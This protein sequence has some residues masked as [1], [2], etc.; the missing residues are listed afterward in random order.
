MLAGVL[1]SAAALA[2]CATKS[3]APTQS[4]GAPPNLAWDFH[5]QQVGEHPAGSVFL[6]VNGVPHKVVPVA[7]AN[8]EQLQRK[9]YKDYSVPGNAVL[10]AQSWHAGF[11]DIVYVL[12]KPG[13]LEVYRQEMDESETSRHPV[14]QVTV[15]PF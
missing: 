8:Y 2:G 5:I 14:K 11:G 9:E 7:T 10:A 3:A 4:S 12:Q 13:Q 1:L 15:I 6:L